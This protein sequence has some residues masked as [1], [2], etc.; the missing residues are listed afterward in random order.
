[1]L[2]RPNYTPSGR[3]DIVRLPLSLLILVAASAVVTAGFLRMILSGLYPPFGSVTTSILVLIGGPWAAV[4]YGRWRNPTLSAVLGV[5][6]G[7]IGFA[8]YFHL[9]Q[10]L[11]WGAP[12]TAINRLP[13]YVA[14][15][16]TTDQWIDRNGFPWLT[17]QPAAPG[18]QPAAPVINAAWFSMNGLNF[19]WESAFLALA[20]GI[21]GWYYAGLPFSERHNRWMRSE[22]CQLDVMNTR[23][24]LDA[25]ASQTVEQWAGSHSRKLLANQW[26]IN[27]DLWYSPATGDGE[28]DLEA[29]IRV[30]KA[31]CARLQPTEIAALI[32][33]IPGL[34]EITG[35]TKEQ[36][37]EQARHDTG[38]PTARI[39]PVPPPFGGRA[40]TA[41][42]RL[43]AE[44]TSDAAQVGIPGLII[45]L[46]IGAVFAME[47]LRQAGWIPPA[48]DW[49]PLV[50]LLVGGALALAAARYTLD[51]K[52]AFV[53]S[54]RTRFERRQ[55]ERALAHRTDSLV[56]ADDP[57]A[58]FVAMLP[59]R[60]WDY[61]RKAPLGQFDHGLVR[62]DTHQRQILFE[63][64]R[65]RCTIPAAAILDWSFETLP[66][67]LADNMAPVC[68]VVQAR[69]GTGI[70]E[71]PFV[72]K[73]RAEENQQQTMSL[74]SQIKTI[75]DRDPGVQPTEPP[76][77]VEAPMPI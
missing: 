24:L 20:G 29:Y 34:Q 5:M 72:P 56:R 6:C 37:A 62:V 22:S 61:P 70:W 63:G 31:P 26:W 57:K 43:F 30:G 48:A 75:C 35:C 39:E 9:D 52:K 44:L 74:Q 14:F 46:S 21:T 25:L 32:V 36:L 2:T 3:F 27:V 4:R 38:A 50:P 77:A 11:R 8:A 47:L 13:R 60:H 55:L 16:I 1:M 73:G 19:A 40:L 64:D 33:L 15:R 66:H 10:C 54:R 7:L 53:V 68:V 71:F 51:P 23:R 17:P 69:L 65:E 49:A 67:Q 12:W 42:N 59:R 45:L 18:A 76:S 41:T 28:I 58:I